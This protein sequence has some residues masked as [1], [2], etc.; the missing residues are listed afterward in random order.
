MIA[1]GLEAFSV[2]GI[3]GLCKFYADGRHVIPP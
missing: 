2:V 3:R 1:I